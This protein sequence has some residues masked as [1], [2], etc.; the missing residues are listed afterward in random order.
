MKAADYVSKNRNV[1]LKF[2]FWNL[3]IVYSFIFIFIYPL[4]CCWIMPVRKCSV[5]V[6]PVRPLTV[7]TYTGWIFQHMYCNVPQDPESVCHSG[8]HTI[9]LLWNVNIQGPKLRILYLKYPVW[10]FK[11]NVT[12]M[13]QGVVHKLPVWPLFPDVNITRWKF[14]KGT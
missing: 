14:D 13:L 9:C 7:C 5:P 8:R 6:C 11:V 12:L 1:I 4:F 2:G 3:F 10:Q